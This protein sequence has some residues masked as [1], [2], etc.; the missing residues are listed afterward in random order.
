MYQSIKPIFKSNLFKITKIKVLKKPYHLTVTLEKLI[1]DIY[2]KK[3]IHK[4]MKVK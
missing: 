3:P 4:L 2:H 1:K